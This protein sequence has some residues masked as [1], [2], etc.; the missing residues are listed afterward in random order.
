MQL[1]ILSI[2]SVFALLFSSVSSMALEKR[3]SADIISPTPGA[4]VTQDST[5]TVKAW[6]WGMSY[7]TGAN[8]TVQNDDNVVIY[9]PVVL[10]YGYNVVNMSVVGLGSY[11]IVLVQEQSSLNYTT[12]QYESVVSTTIVPF[13]VVDKVSAETDSTDSKIASESATTAFATPTETTT[14]TATETSAAATAT[15]TEASLQ[16]QKTSAA[17]RVVFG[18]SY[19]WLV[20]LGFGVFALL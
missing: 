20:A 17:E 8:Y 5:I 4:V 15:A 12:N 1:S 9:G 3:D 14:G 16:N 13:T 18:S 2:V 11:K 19:L 6:R 10:D 7:L